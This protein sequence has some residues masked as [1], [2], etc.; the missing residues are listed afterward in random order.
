LLEQLV[1]KGLTCTYYDA[2]P[3]KWP[4]IEFNVITGDMHQIATQLPRKSFD[5]VSC[6]HTLEHSLNPLFVLWQI[7]LLLRDGG[8]ALIIVPKYNSYWA[9]F[10]T[11]FNCLP[12]DNWRMLFYRSGFRIDQ[13]D[14]GFWD[15]EQKSTWFEEHRFVLSVESRSIRLDTPEN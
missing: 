13:E 4:K 14:E 1:D 3:P 12:I 2:F 6:R 5:F 11:H 8:K 9:W 10:Y 15:D 7:N